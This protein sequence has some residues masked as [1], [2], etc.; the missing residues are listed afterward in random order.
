MTEE[1]RHERI[2]GRIAQVEENATAIGR[3]LYAVEEQT[4]AAE[5]LPRRKYFRK[6]AIL[7]AAR[8]DMDEVTGLRD[9]NAQLLAVT[10]FDLGIARMAVH[11]DDW[12]RAGGEK[13]NLIRDLVPEARGEDD[14]T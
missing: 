5:R 6:R 4:E 10:W 11:I 1:E 3:L 2:A 9:A 14:A 7:R 12:R 8:R 13:S